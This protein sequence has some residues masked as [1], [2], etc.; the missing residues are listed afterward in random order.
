MEGLGASATADALAPPGKFLRKRVRGARVRNGHLRPTCP[1][2][3]LQMVIGSAQL[4]TS[5][6]S[7]EQAFHTSDVPPAAREKKLGA[8]RAPPRAPSARRTR[9]RPPRPSPATLRF[10]RPMLFEQPARPSWDASVAAHVPP[11]ER[12]GAALLAFDHSH[13]ET[14]FRAEVLPRPLPL[15]TDAWGRPL[16]YAAHV[17]GAAGALVAPAASAGRPAASAATQG[18]GH[19]ARSEASGDAAA[20]AAATAARAGREGG[21]RPIGATGGTLFPRAAEMPAHPALA[22]KP[23]WDAGTYSVVTPAERAAATAAATTAARVATAARQ[24]PL[25]RGRYR[26]LVARVE[27]MQAALRARRAATQ[28]AIAEELAR[29]ASR[30]ASRRSAE[31]KDGAASAA[32]LGEAPGRRT[33]PWSTGFWSAVLPP[34][35]DRS[36]VRA[37]TAHLGGRREPSPPPEYTLPS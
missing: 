11:C 37:A 16:G 24:A 7:D 9:R 30:S 23:A 29:G 1:R 20:V 13:L 32:S 22:D 8:G 5:Y 3:A 26:P 6:R 31:R 28:A 4:R 21:G 36:A 14:N 25:L 2:L 35:P 33:A 10:K 27:D 17:G 34:V 12:A 15:R 19:S 18:G